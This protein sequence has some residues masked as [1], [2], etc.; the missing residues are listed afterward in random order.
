M[1]EE[2]PITPGPGSSEVAGGVARDRGVEAVEDA[3]SAPAVE[4]G[5]AQAA[6]VGDAREQTEEQDEESKMIDVH[7]PHGGLHTWKDF[8]IHL[9]TITLGLLIAIS[10][11]QSVEWLHHLHQRHQLEDDLHAEAEKNLAIMDDDYRYFDVLL[12]QVA[13]NRERVDAMRAGGGKVK[14]SYLPFNNPHAS[15][16]GSTTP[17]A[18]VWTTAKESEL[19]ALLPREEA[20]FYDRV[21]R[22]YD[23]YMTATEHQQ[24]SAME[25]KSFEAQ[26]AATPQVPWAW[27]TTYPDLS[28]MSAAQ[29]DQ[30]S[31][32]LTKFWM[33]TSAVRTRL[34]FFSTVESAVLRGGVSDQD[35]LSHLVHRPVTP[36]PAQPDSAADP[37][38]E[39]GTGKP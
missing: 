7:V 16:V 32:L 39:K 19:V 34:D 18:S 20:R 38:S 33:A 10:L 37:P 13:A 14:L 26:F 1:L 22:Q 30:E 21:Y 31:A 24:E 6:V 25:M 36:L 29:L 11:E 27:L 12:A 4:I 5:L 8:W 2:E 15:G 28:R 3:A 35:V 17:L 9:G 23:I